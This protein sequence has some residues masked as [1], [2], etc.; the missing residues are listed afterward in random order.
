[1]PD[2]EDEAFEVFLARIDERV[3]S[4]SESSRLRQLR[5]DSDD[6]DALTDT[7][8][9]LP[10]TD[11]YPLWR[12]RCRVTILFVSNEESVSCLS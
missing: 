10:T 9:R 1:M 8:N 5:T 4:Q 2:E 3:Q 7:L 12:V 11:D 6:S